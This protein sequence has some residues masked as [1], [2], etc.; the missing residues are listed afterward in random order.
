MENFPNLGK[1]MNIKIQEAQRTPIRFNKKPTIKKA[2]HSQI[3]KILRQAENHEIR[4]GKKDPAYRGRQVRIAADLSTETW[5]ARREWQ[6]ISNV[7]NQKNMKPRILYPA[8][9]SFKIEEEI[10]SF[11]DKQKL[12]EFTTTKPTLQEILKGTL[13][14]KERPKETKTTKEQGKSPETTTL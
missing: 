1:D 14:G 7:L 8:R 4:K 10:K 9:L 5:Q 6:D 13:S 12:K 11:P 3:H 2:Y